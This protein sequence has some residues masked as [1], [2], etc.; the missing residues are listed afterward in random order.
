MWITLFMNLFN[1]PS[2]KWVWTSLQSLI[3]KVELSNGS[4]HF[5]SASEWQTQHFIEKPKNKETNFSL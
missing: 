4:A 3:G 1:K 5:G 2:T